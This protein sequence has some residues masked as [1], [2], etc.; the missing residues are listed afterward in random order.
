MG[1]M[2]SP[3]SPLFTQ[4]FIQEQIKE[5]IKAPWGTHRW[6]VNVLHKWP[7]TQKMFPFDDIISIDF[8]TKYMYSHMT[9][10]KMHFKV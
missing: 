9:F 4:L 3:A 10:I 5:N 1:V 6:L 2:V 8:E 7:A